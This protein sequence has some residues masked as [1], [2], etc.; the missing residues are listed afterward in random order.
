MTGDGAVVRI[1]WKLASKTAERHKT[2]TY[3]SPDGHGDL[4]HAS[5]NLA[6]AYLAQAAEIERLT[7]RV[8]TLCLA[9]STVRANHAHEIA[10]AEASEA[11]AADLL[12]ALE[13]AADRLDAIVVTHAK[14]FPP[15]EYGQHSL[16]TLTQWAQ[17]T[18]A[19]IAAAKGETV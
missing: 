6:R 17:E 5:G 9:L 16:A 12:K 4:D 19:A 3:S 11:R 7:N 14:A 18:R 1:D 8:D 10:R 2:W 13:R 15:P